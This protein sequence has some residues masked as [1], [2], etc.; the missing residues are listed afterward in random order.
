M[1][2]DAFMMRAVISEINR[3]LPDAKI[4]KVLQ[5]LPDEIDL[6]VHSGKRSARLLFN[7]GPSAPRMGITETVKENPL[8]APML[9]MQLR[10]LLVGGR[11]TSCRQLGGDRIAVLEVS[12]FDEMGYPAVRRIICE[13][14]GKY[15]NL[16]LT[17]ENDKII[18]A[19]KPVDFAASSVRQVLPGLKYVAPACQE[20]RSLLE[21]TEEGFSMALCAFSQERS[22][23][24]FITSTY[25]G[26]A[27]QIA[28]EICYRATGALDVPLCRADK[29]ALKKTFFAWQTL[30]KEESYSPTLVLSAEGEP[31]DYSYMD[32]THLG[33]GFKKLTFDSI[34][35]LLD[36]HF[37]E[38]DRL[39]RL[40]Q[41]G[42]DLVTLINNAIQRTER[43]L[44]VQKQTLLDSQR[45]EEHK[46]IGDLITAN[47]YAIKRGMTS[48]SCIDYYDDGAPTVTVELDSRLSPAQNAQR[49]YKLY[50]KAKTAR[51]ILTGQ[52]EKWEEELAYLHT[53]KEFF[54]RA[55]CE[56]DLAEIREELYRAGYGTRLK[57]YRSPKQIR[58]RPIR[59][60]TPGGY[61]L[62]VGRNNIQNDQLSMKLAE[63]SD[64]WFH[65]KDAPG[66]HVIMRTYGEEPSEADYTYAAGVAAKYSSVKSGK[67]AVDYTA[68]KN[69][70]K[71][72]GS[73][74]GFVTYKTNYTAYVSPLTEEELNLDRP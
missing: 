38:K 12:C 73:K 3:E 24:K 59:L 4:E 72:Q 15:A 41:R 47:I 30:L 64:I 53:V 34:G 17:D 49:A 33:D 42:K 61:E 74:P 63:K 7:A 32:I 9:C 39:T 70:K 10:K 18:T 40:H 46:C 8:K 14:M 44:A 58:S 1:A 52:I 50:N 2:F 11:I 31:I 35:A 69:L 22:V 68:V 20:R 5:P 19:L 45:A 54:D 6:A 51:E 43:K 37:A 29:S 62:L 23:E 13:I 56:D 25:S 16:I 36:R 21:E 48:F 26:V 27:T 65:V 60:T 67:V 28:R 55:E 71:P 57:D 66:S